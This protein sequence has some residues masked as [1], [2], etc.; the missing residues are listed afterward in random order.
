M[1][2]RDYHVLDKDIKYHIDHIYRIIVKLSNPILN[3]VSTFDVPQSLYRTVIE[4]VFFLPSN[5]F[6]A[7]KHDGAVTAVGYSG[8]GTFLAAGD[9]NRKIKV[10]N[11]AEDYVNKTGQEMQM[12]NPRR[13]WDHEMHLCCLDVA[14][15]ALYCKSE[16]F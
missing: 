3:L 9:A 14:E 8:N 11:I 10:Y 4:F 6:Q 15:L 2:F 13:V 1:R 16:M 7:L 5:L 12:S